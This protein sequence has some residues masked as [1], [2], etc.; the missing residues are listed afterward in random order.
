MMFINSAWIDLSSVMDGS[1]LLAKGPFLTNHG[2][3]E[4]LLEG[5]SEEVL[6]AENSVEERMRGYWTERESEEL[7]GDHL[8]K[9][10][11]IHY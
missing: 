9:E 1:M 6:K 11:K 8:W 4:V 7:P 10:F 3:V 5:C 2:S